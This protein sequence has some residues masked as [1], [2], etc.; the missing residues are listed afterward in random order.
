MIYVFEIY[1][2]E[3]VDFKRVIHID[4]TQTFESLHRIIQDTSGYDSSQL[5]SFFITDKSWSKKIEICMLDNGNKSE[6]SYSMQNTGL[7]KFITKTGQKLVYVFDYFNERFFYLELIEKLMKNDLQEPF[8]AFEKGSAPSQFLISDYDSPE[9]ELLDSSDSGKS[10]G[11][12]EDYYE[13]FGEM[14]V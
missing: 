5:A 4:S 8:V 1:S 10:F 6:L 14:D 13:I 9:V 2:S 3:S 11:D 12:L 7:D